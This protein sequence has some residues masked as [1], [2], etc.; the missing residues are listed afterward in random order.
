MGNIG[1]EVNKRAQAF[2][3]RV[4]YHNRKQLATELEAGATYYSDRA[5]FLATAD[6][7]AICLPS[8]AETYHIIDKEAISH[9]KAAARIVNISRGNTID[10]D[11]MIEA[12]QAGHLSALGLDVHEAEVDDDRKAKQGGALVHPFLLNDPRCTVLPVWL[13]FTISSDL[14]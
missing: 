5:A 8:N 1:R 7:L 2:G 9:L 14:C 4:I 6:C 12:L 10:E 13:F 11:V 3:M